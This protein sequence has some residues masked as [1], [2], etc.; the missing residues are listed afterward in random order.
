MM[1][2]VSEKIQDMGHTVK[3]KLGE[4]GN[5]ISEEWNKRVVRLFPLSYRILYQI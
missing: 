5:K 4:A 3:E 1:E 2:N